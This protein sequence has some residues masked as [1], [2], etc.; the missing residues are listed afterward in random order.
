MFII[1]GKRAYG[2]VH[3][4]GTTSVQTVFGH[5]YYLPLIP[6]SS[7]YVDFKTGSYYQLNNLD[8]RSILC[9]YLRIWMPLAFV[10]ALV[11]FDMLD[12]TASKVLCG[13]IMA[14]SAVAGIGSFIFDKKVVRH[15]SAQVREIMHRH[16]GVALDPYHCQ[17]SLQAEIEDRVRA[18][19]D[20]P[21][22]VFWYKSTL[23]DA[24]SQP[25]LVDMAVL[26]ARC[27]R[28]DKP[29]QARALQRLPGVRKVA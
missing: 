5:L 16:F 23:D 6:M 2:A 15:E 11:A 3:K 27:D 10:I 9:G 20:E 7:H 21:L 24:V 13:L 1:W 8:G 18:H 25:H 19:S 12:N 4:V 29:L 28:H 17:A 14:L 26:R 22:D